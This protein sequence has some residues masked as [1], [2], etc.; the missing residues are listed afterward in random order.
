[1]ST[2]EQ[3][4]QDKIDEL[5]P[6]EPIDD[7]DLEEIDLNWLAPIE[8]VSLDR[9]AAIS[10]GVVIGAKLEILLADAG[11]DHGQWSRACEAWSARLARDATLVIASSVEAAMRRVTRRLAR[12]SIAPNRMS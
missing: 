11:I 4:L 8:G 1:M 2:L 7:K 12:G 10:A 9:W 5:E 6:Y 3:L